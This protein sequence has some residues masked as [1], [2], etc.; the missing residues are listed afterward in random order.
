MSFITRLASVEYLPRNK[1]RNGRLLRDR[2][3]DRLDIVSIVDRDRITKICRAH[4]IDV[5]THRVPGTGFVK[6]A[7]QFRSWMNNAAWR[8]LR[9]KDY[10]NKLSV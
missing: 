9:K 5:F 4:V 3:S 2:L 1:I 7:Q 8:T 10:A 6:I